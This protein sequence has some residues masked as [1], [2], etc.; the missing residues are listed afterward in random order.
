MIDNVVRKFSQKNFNGYQNLSKFFFSD[1][2]ETEK[3]NLLDK[4]VAEEINF[5]NL[6]NNSKTNNHVSS[7]SETCS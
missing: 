4:I 7:I 2:N 5:E 3:Y 6:Y 1:L